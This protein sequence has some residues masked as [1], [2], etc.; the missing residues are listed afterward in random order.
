MAARLTLIVQQPSPPPLA[1]VAGHISWAAPPLVQAAA[2]GAKA[3]AGC[4]R[5]LG[6][7]PFQPT[8][9][10]RQALRLGRHGRFPQDSCE[11]N[12]YAFRTTRAVCSRIVRLV[13]R[14][15]APN[16]RRLVLRGRSLSEPLTKRPSDRGAGEDIAPHPPAAVVGR[17]S[18]A[19]GQIS[20]IV[21]PPTIVTG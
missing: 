5:R 18:A 8:S 3:D 10:F 20:C 15:M 17:I 12:H 21:R 13:A 16:G 4:T 11:Q 6:P 7:H 14:S 1:A 9:R 19:A 2:L